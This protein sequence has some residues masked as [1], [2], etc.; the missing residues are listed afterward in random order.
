M[1]PVRAKRAP[2]VALVCAAVLAVVALCLAVRSCGGEGA[3]SADGTGSAAAPEDVSVEEVL[4]AVVPP[5]DE[6]DA[7]RD[8]SAVGRDV[9]DLDVCARLGELVE[10]AS[11]GLGVRATWEVAAGLEECA[12]DILGQY[13][14]QGDVSLAY[15]GAVDLLGQVWGCVVAA[16]EGWAELVL[17][18]ARGASE[19]GRED[20]NGG[21]SCSVT[22]VRFG[23]EA[24]AQAA[25]GGGA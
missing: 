7:V 21:T 16:D 15:D 14:A 24:V 11:G 2:A 6:S 5:A 9:T 17:V 23:Q 19:E 13:E 20:G 22:L 10:T 12:A 25:A 8:G 1:N 18:D 4:E 3:V